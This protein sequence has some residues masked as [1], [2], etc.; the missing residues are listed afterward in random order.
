[1]IYSCEKCRD[2]Y[3]LDATRR[4]ITFTGSRRFIWSLP[5]T[6]AL[7]GTVPSSGFSSRI[8]GAVTNTVELGEIILV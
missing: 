3:F 1:V 7:F 5:K 2:T 4:N 6:A 8:R